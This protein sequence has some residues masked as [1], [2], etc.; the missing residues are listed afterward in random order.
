MLLDNHQQKLPVHL[1][2][3]EGVHLHAVEGV[4]GD[5]LRDAS[6]V[7]DLCVV[8]HTA[9]Q[10]VRDARGAA[11]APRNL[12]RAGVVYLGAEYLGRAAD[13]CGQF[14]VR[15]EVEVKD[16][17]E[18]SAQRRGNQTGPRRRADECELGQV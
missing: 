3:P 16:D 13:D 14:L 18:A 11:R 9:Q 4:V 7:L 15:V 12:A 5:L 1:V 6:R 2:E 10:T 17:A 8:A